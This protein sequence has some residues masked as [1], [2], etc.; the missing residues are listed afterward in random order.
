MDFQTSVQDRNLI[1]RLT[2]EVDHHTSE[3]LR[4]K[5]EKEYDRQNARHIIFDMSDVT[6][7]DSSGI[8]MIMGRYKAIEQQG[9]QV[10]VYGVNVSIGKIMQI[11]GLHKI[12]PVYD[13]LEAAKQAMR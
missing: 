12:I 5:I 7:M 6:F 4:L 3:D 10:A 13:S 9:G 1:I 11:S 2:G 8:G